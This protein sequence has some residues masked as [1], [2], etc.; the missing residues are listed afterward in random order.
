MF[1]NCQDLLLMMGTEIL[2]IDAPWAKKLTKTRVQFLVAPTVNILQ[3][4][5]SLNL[6]LIEFIE[7]FY[8]NGHHIVLY[9]YLHEYLIDQ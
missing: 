5:F 8:I 1:W 2:K 6:T 4:C 9:Y 7:D 3:V